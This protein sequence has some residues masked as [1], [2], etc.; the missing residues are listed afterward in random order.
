[1]NSIPLFGYASVYPPID[2]HLSCLQF[3]VIASKATVKISV[4]VF[5]EHMFLFILGKYLRVE[6]LGYFVD[7]YITFYEINKLFPM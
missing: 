2:G 6:W 4:R 3:L 5:V 7:L 1:M